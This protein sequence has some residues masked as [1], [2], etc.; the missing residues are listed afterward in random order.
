MT[1]TFSNFGDLTSAMAYDLIE[2]IQAIPGAFASFGMSNQSCSAYVAVKFYGESEALE[3][4]D[5]NYEFKVRFSDHSDRHGS[6]ITIRIDDVIQTIESDGDYVA[7]T[8]TSDN[9]SAKMRSAIEAVEAFRAT[10][11]EPERD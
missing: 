4:E 9:Y 10:L 2:A 1:K 3:D 5:G 8:I 7:T 6:D 11:S